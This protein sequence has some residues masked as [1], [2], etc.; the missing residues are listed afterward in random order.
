MLLDINWK[1]T[2]SEELWKLI[3]RAENLSGKSYSSWANNAPTLTRIMEQIIVLSR[4]ECAWEVYFTTLMMLFYLVRRDDVLNL[5]EAFKVAEI[6]LHDYSLYIDQAI[7]EDSNT[8]HLS[9][10]ICAN[11][12][13][14]YLSY[15]QITD[16]KM[17]QMLNLF[18]ENDSKFGVKYNTYNYRTILKLGLLN[19]DRDMVKRAQVKLEATDYKYG[20]YICHYAIQ[21]MDYYI[22]ND[23][24]DGMIEIIQRVSEKSIPAR[25]KPC[26]DTCE[27]GN[28]TDMVS[29]VLH[30]CLTLGKAEFF[31]RLFTEKIHIYRSPCTDLITSAAVFHALAGDWLLLDKSLELAETDNRSREQHKQVPL[32]S[33]YEALYWKS[34]FHLLD[35]SGVH[36]VCLALN[37]SGPNSQEEKSVWS[38]IDAAAY[39]EQQADQIGAQMKASRKRFQYELMKQTFQKCLSEP[40]IKNGQ[41]DEL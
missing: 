27:N 3:V 36:T 17:E 39:F 34:F 31:L 40:I 5:K 13:E 12:I 10:C 11:I 8:G 2:Y 28:E 7:A 21:V 19:H 24:Y 26:Y 35:N 23:D 22:Y 18:Y 33:M 9:Y 41:I 25:Y 6:Y 30:S 38:C 29:N 1:S 16:E 15:P 20:C 32:E 4:K 14:F 37:C